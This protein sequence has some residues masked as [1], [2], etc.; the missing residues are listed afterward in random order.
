V[1]YSEVNLTG[2]GIEMLKLRL[3]NGHILEKP[4]KCPDELYAVM[5]KCWILNREK[6]INLSQLVT[7]MKSVLFELYEIKL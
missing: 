1:P 4:E 2:V 3:M 7:E 6:R 5:R